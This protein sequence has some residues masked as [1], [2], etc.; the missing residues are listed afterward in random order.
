[1]SAQA[2]LL[3]WRH[4]FVS[5]SWL[6]IKRIRFLSLPSMVSEPFGLGVKR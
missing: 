3:P 4:D 5:R 1:M 2:R 6:S